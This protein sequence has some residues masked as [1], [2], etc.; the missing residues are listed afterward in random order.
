MKSHC[1]L[2]HHSHKVQWL[3]RLDLVW[4]KYVLELE[5]EQIEQLEQEVLEE[6]EVLVAIIINPFVTNNILMTTNQ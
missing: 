2:Q 4:E 1:L 6:Q 3:L 5:L